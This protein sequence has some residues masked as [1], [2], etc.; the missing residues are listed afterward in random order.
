MNTD[1]LIVIALILWIETWVAWAHEAWD[2]K[3]WQTPLRMGFLLMPYIPVALWCWWRAGWAPPSSLGE[4]LLL[5]FVGAS[6]VA[7]MLTIDE[8][9]LP[10]SGWA[11]ER[12]L[13][14]DNWHAFLSMPS[15][16]P[17]STFLAVYYTPWYVFIPLGGVTWVIW[18]LWDVAYGNPFHTIWTDAI[19]WLRGDRE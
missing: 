5:T 17:L 6:F 13:W 3:P 18:Q 1:T 19:R 9:E 11:W 12:I 4:I 15:H 7:H 2:T 8:L 16:W 10:R 14:T